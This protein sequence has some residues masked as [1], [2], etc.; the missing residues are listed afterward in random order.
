MAKTMTGRCLCGAVSY[1]ASGVHTGY[2]GCHCSMCRRWGGGP[3]F[4]VSVDGVRF[5]GEDAI[6]RYRSSEWAERGFCARCGTSISYA[7]A[8]RAG[9]LDLTLAS[10]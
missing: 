2:H 3:A 4:A 6:S 10:L 5:E 1:E 9:E 7:F 8:G